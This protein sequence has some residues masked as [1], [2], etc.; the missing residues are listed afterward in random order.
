VAGFSALQSIL[1]QSSRVHSVPDARMP[2]KLGGGN[3]SAGCSLHFP[4]TLQKAEGDL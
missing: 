4:D 1:F 3:A 2:L